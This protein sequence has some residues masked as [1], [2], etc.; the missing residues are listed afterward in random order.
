MGGDAKLANIKSVKVNLT[1]TA[2]TPQGEF[3]MDMESIIVYPDHLH[4]VLQTPGGPM[5][6]ILTPDFGIA[7]IEN[8]GTQPMPAQQK[9]ETLQQLKRDPIY[10]TAHWK[11]PDVFFYA[12]GTVKVGDIDARVLYVNIAGTSVRW[13]V[14]PMNGHI[15][16]ATYPTFSQSGEPVQGETI[17][18]DWKTLDGLTVPMLR[19]N[20]QNGEDS[21]QVEYKTVEINPTVDPKLFEKPAQK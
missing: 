18:D 20:K 12:A 6:L 7:S 4:A 10:I 14:D 13:L 2:K 16:K 19:K 15:L 21:S 11:D 5:T 9:D 8:M 17:F 1:L 3:P